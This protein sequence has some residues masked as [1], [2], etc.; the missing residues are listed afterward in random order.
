MAVYIYREEEIDGIIRAQR[1]LRLRFCIG[2]FIIL[3]AACVVALARPEW[4]FGVHERARF[5]VIGALFVFFAGPLGENLLR[6]RSRPARLRESLARTSVE[7]SAEGIRIEEP[8]EIRQ[9]ARGEILRAEETPW[10][11]YL[12][13]CDR[14]RWMFVSNRIAEFRELKWEVHEF[15]IP[16]VQASSAPNGEELAGVVI[17]AATMICAI[18]AH[19]VATLAVN[20][21]V[22]ILIAIAGFKIVSANPDNLPK[23]R[24]ARLGI[25]LPVAMTAAMLWSAIH[26]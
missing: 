7:V 26:R 3:L 18:F 24:W 5:W 14:Y 17:F 10:G 1:R 6:W 19:S 8:G 15:G 25:L 22:A 13:T 20:L 4:I 12:R 2:V 11:M 23:M 21:G 9:L 16:V